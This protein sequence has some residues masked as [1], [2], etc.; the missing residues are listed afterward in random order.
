MFSQSQGHG[1]SQDGGDAFTQLEFTQNDEDEATRFGLMKNMNGANG[2][3]NITQSA[4]PS[5][6]LLHRDEQWGRLICSNKLGTPISLLPKVP[7]NAVNGSD[8]EGNSQGEM[9]SSFVTNA[10]SP[11]ST[12]QAAGAPA[13]VTLMGCKLSPGDLF[14]EYILGRSSKCD[15]HIKP[16]DDPKL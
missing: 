3:A 10:L 15:I 9:T 7:A 5:N 4:P 8:G 13:I 2:A 1:A 11:R 14:N 12:G 6:A 16:P